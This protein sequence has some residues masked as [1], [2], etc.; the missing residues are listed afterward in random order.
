MRLKQGALSL[1]A[2]AED[3]VLLHLADR[4]IHHHTTCHPLA[5]PELLAHLEVDAGDGMVFEA[6]H[7]LALGRRERR[8]DIDSAQDREWEGAHDPI[9]AE[10]IQR[11]SRLDDHLHPLGILFDPYDLRAIVDSLSKPSR[12][13]RTHPPG[14]V[15]ASMATTLCPAEDRRRAVLGSTLCQ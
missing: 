11:A 5:V 9:G 13:V 3:R 7:N 8:V 1:C 12:S 4:Q 15:C 14:R 2:R 6:R 10:P